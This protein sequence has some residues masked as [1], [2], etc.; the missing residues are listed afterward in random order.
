MLQE[1]MPLLDRMA[2]YLNP[3]G[4]PSGVHVTIYS[5][6]HHP[7]HAKLRPRGTYRMFAGG[8]I[9]GIYSNTT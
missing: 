3:L 1:L 5:S 7:P 2:A 9:D 4:A 8:S 6:Q